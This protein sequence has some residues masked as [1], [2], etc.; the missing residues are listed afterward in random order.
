MQNKIEADKFN[1]STYIRFACEKDIDAIMLFIKEYWS[2]THILAHDREIF[3][4]QYV[5][6]NEVCFVL[7]LEK[8]TEEIEGVLGYIPYSTQG[9]RD[10][11]TAL[12]KVKKGKNMF[13]GMELLYYLEEYANCKNVYCAGINQSTFS[14]YKYMKK[15]IA[16]LEH[17]YMLNDTAINTIALIKQ[18]KTATPIE[19]D[20]IIE[21]ISDFSE[22]DQNFIA[23]YDSYPKK[24]VEYIKRRYFQHPEYVYQIIQIE[25]G[26]KKG[27]LIGREQ[28]WEESKIFRIIDFIGDEEC[29]AKAGRYLHS[30][31]IE[32]QYEYI[33]MM[34]FGIA[35]ELLLQAGFVKVETQDENII[36]NYFE[37]FLQENV[38]VFIF[39]PKNVKVRMFKGDG[40]QDRPNRRTS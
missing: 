15:E 13:Q 29:L 10:I 25:T 19:S 30:L 14:I 36:P 11:F 39:Y 35:D 8:E 7:S 16:K 5:Y 1:S 6:G 26:K 28:S 17:Y 4:F 24:S 12:W 20:A 34:Q 32:R 22:M 33:D 9:K 23:G 18:K 3:E 21:K 31:M 2:E 37:P 27:Y 40:D 38:N